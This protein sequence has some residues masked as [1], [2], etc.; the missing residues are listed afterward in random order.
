MEKDS[1][2]V[3]KGGILSNLEKD[4]DSAN[5]DPID[6]MISKSLDGAVDGTVASTDDEDI[7][8]IED[9]QS[10][11]LPTQRV[12]ATEEIQ[13]R[14][15]PCDSCQVHSNVEL[16]MSDDNQVTDTGKA[17][18]QKEKAEVETAC[19]GIANNKDLDSTSC[20]PVVG[21][22]V[23]EIID[24]NHSDPNFEVPMHVTG[25]D[26]ELKLE[27]SLDKKVEQESGAVEVSAS[28]NTGSLTRDGRQFSGSNSSSGLE[29][30]EEEE[31]EHHLK[32]EGLNGS[33]TAVNENVADAEL[34]DSYEE[35]KAEAEE[36]DTNSE[37]PKTAEVEE[38]QSTVETANGSTEN[39]YDAFADSQSSQPPTQRVVATEEIEN[40]SMPCD[41][42][43]VH[44][45][46]ELEIRDDNQVT[47]TGKA[48][49][50][51]EKAEVETACMDFANNKDLDST[52]CHPVVGGEVAEIIDA[53]HSDPNFEVPMHV[54][55][56]DQEL[57]L[58]ESLDKK[59]EQESGAVEV[60]ASTNTGSLTRD[61]RQFSGSNSSSGL[62]AAEEEEGEHHLKV[63]GLNGSKT[64]VNENVADAELVDSYEEQKAEAEEQDTNSEE[65]KTAEGESTKQADLQ[66]E[67]SQSSQPPTQRVVATEEIENRSMPCDSLQVHSNVELEIRDDNQVTDT[68]KAGLQKEKAEVE[69]ACMDFANNKD[70][71]STSCHPVV[72]GEVA[73]I[74]D[75]IHSDPNFEVPMHVTG[76]DQ[77]LKLEESLDKKVEQESGAVEVSASTNT[78]SLTRDARQ[79][80]GSNSSSGLEAAEEEEGEHHLK[81]EGLNGSKTA[82]NENVADAELVDSYEE[83]KAE[84]E[85]QDTNSEEPKTAEVEEMQS[86]V[87]TANG[88]TENL[89]DAFADS[90]SSQPP[91]QRVVA[92]EEIQNRSMPCDSCQVHSNVELEIR[93][94]NQV[95][96]TGKAGLQKEKSEVETACMDF[97][98]NKDLDS[99]SCH[100]V[101]GGEVA[102]IIDAIHSD[103]NFEVP[104]HVTGKDQELK[105]EESLDKKVEQE[106]GA[107]EV[108]ASTDTVSLTTDG[109]QFSGSNSSSGLAAPEEEEG[110]HHLKVEGLNGNKT[111]VNENVAD[112]ELVDSYEEQKTEAE[113][114]DTDSEEPKATEAESTKQADLQIED[115]QSSQPPTQQVATE[116]IENRSMPCD[117]C[118]VHLN[119]ELEMRDE[120]QVTDTGKAGLQ[121]EKSEVETACMGIANNKDLDS[122]S[123]HPVVGGEVAEIDDT[124]H[125]DLNFEVPMHVTGK[126][127]E[128]KLEESLDKKVEQESGAVEV[129]VSTNTVSLT[130]DGRQFSG[131]NSSSGLEAPEEEEGD[132]HLKVEGLNGNKTAV[133]ENVADAELVDSYEEQKTEAEEQDT[134]SEEPKATEAES[135]KQADLQIEDSQSSQPPTQRV[136]ATEEI[137]NRIMPCDSCQVNSNVELEIRDDNQVTDTGKAGLQ[138]EKAEV[139]TACMD[140]ANN[141]DLDSTSCH[142]VVGGEVAEIDDTIHSDP[143]FEVPMHVTGKDQEL[144]LEES[145]DK[146]VEQESGAVEVSACTNTVSLTIDGRQFSG[147][148]SSS[149]LEA[150]EEEADH[151]LKVEALNG[152]KTAVNK[153]VADAELVDSYEEQKP[154]AE[155]QDIDSEEPKTTEGKSTK[156]ADLQIEG[157]DSDAFNENFCFSVEEL[158]STVETAN[159]STENQYD[160]FADSQSSQLPTQLVVATEE[161][162]N[163]SMPCDSCQVHSNVVLEMRDDN[164]V[165]DTGK[166]GLQKEKVEAE[167]VCMGIANNKDLDSTSCHPVVG[168]EVVEIDDTIHS[169]LN[170]EVSMHVTRKDQELKLEESLD[171]KVEQEPGAVEVSVSTNTVSLTIDGRQFSGSNSSSGLEAPEEEEG[172][173]HLKVEGLNGNKT[174]VNENGADA[175]LVDSYEEQK[176]EAEEQDTDSQEPKTTEGKS[177]KQVALREI[178]V[179][180]N[181]ATYQLPP[182]DVGD[183]GVSDLVW[184]KVRSHPWWPGQIFHPS[185]ASEKAMKYHKKDCF[186][187]AYFGDRTFAWNDASVLKPFR[188]HFSQVQKQSNSETFQNAVNCALEE[189]S[190]RVEFG[191]ACPCIPEDIYNKIKHQM[192]ENAGV[193][194]ES[195]IQHGMEKSSSANLFEPGK[196]VEYMKAVAQSP[197]GGVDRVQIVIARS[198]LLAFYR[199]KGYSELPEF[200]FCGGL[201]DDADTLQNED[202]LTADMSP[203]DMSPFHKDDVKI[204]SGQQI[205]QTQKRSYRK[206]KHNLKDNLYPKKKER[207][208]PELVVE[209]WDSIDDEFGPDGKANNKLVSPSS[210]KKRRGPDSLADESERRKTA[211]A[212]SSVSLPKPSFKIGDCIRRVASQMT[213]SPSIL[214]C[215]SQKIDESSDGLVADGS[216]VLVQESEDAEMNNTTVSTEYSSLDELL[217]QLY[218]AARDPFKG[219]GFLTVIVSFFSDFR[220]A[221][222]MEEREKVS[223]K[224]RQLTGGAPETFEFEDMND[225]YWTDR[226]IQ[227]GSEEQPPRKSRKRD[228]QLASGDPDKPLNKSNY[229]KRNSDV[230]HSLSAE[231]P[232][233]HADENAPAELVM[234]F[235]VVDSVPSEASLVKMF[236]RFGPLKETETEIDK[237]T[238]RARVV[239][240]KCSDAEA[241]YSSATKFNIFGSMLVNYQL[242]NTITVPFKTEPLVTFQGEE[243][244]T[245]FL[246]F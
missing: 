91:T 24:A 95:T 185:D 217:L 153:N 65:P 179:K 145:L 126:D 186:L 99:T 6:N 72:G 16:E 156:Q 63:E 33:K 51:K 222:I 58:E 242:N 201:L 94:D 66:I 193:R 176:T 226:V 129:S 172:D 84:A 56:K 102:E 210:R 199:M 174:A 227:N 30:A 87:E 90:Q 154:E 170:F 98:N 115:S 139:E 238:N 165:T 18:L 208:M 197:A 135:T 61:G 111:A 49:L 148:N 171:K 147:S 180:G 119:V 128:L 35:Q 231:K 9:S 40:R 81:V 71:D 13:N 88:S 190:R 77:E 149:G 163:R 27:E 224:K 239:F 175:E 14:S 120:T 228:N 82:V 209:S 192:V 32:V 189:V 229:R 50:Q 67:D 64:A 73:E 76:K 36:Q 168:G 100:P 203:L 85:E 62:E 144:K 89:F 178:T 198:Q 212:C 106:S 235:P 219:Y 55:G 74:D 207:S 70:L 97:A 124:I 83:Q 103:P 162:Q 21:G 195:C 164:Q 17:D 182:D 43:Q 29:A 79:F 243:D 107:V 196:L 112:A 157:M 132:H 26:Q 233:S 2:D 241:A 75:T 60:S 213:G 10:S 194:Q 160:A 28:T 48:G 122:T 184:G 191:L 167:T 223:G 221:A 166:A 92:T 214:K 57:K 177:T 1:S 7:T 169:D 159:G 211:K 45:N 121:K 143:N 216:D 11:Q 136:V 68:G 20:H 54:T 42:C 230:N 118:Q 47:D 146:K 110:D 183:F 3:V 104:M 19:M 140:F 173:H 93:D 138:K 188:S 53:N 234:H 204:S 8:N 215:N 41:S 245:V 237:D 59:V 114:Q 141:K 133:N 137:Q 44:S 236:K 31:G 244:A 113:E 80:S 151:H 12:V 23:A 96:D 127:Q 125:S 5:R 187:V 134:D 78:G 246:Q 240:K 232:V 101:V 117:S 142:P 123:C 220:N 86:T 52:S 131:S 161:I 181:G 202:K 22:E 46:V 39:L 130:I 38:M 37:E 225:T 150:P 152:N 155:E 206:R 25:K 34:V 218:L 205:V 4:S 108:S 105:L 158:Q 15:M 109:R 116:E 200:Q 69:T